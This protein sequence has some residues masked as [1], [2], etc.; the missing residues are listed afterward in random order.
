MNLKEL[1]EYFYKKHQELWQRV[2]D[3]IKKYGYYEDIA[4]IKEKVAKHKGLKNS[5]FGCAL[6]TESLYSPQ[7]EECFLD[8]LD[9]C[10]NNSLYQEL[11]DA[12][13]DD[14]AIIC[15]IAISDCGYRIVPECEE[16]MR[17]LYAK[18]ENK[19]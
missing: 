12:E 16:R 11:L 4:N 5:C 3:Y 19:D 17:K 10:N 18:I 13:D 8:D 6:G 1:H 9:E 15:A 2:I 14:E 7:C